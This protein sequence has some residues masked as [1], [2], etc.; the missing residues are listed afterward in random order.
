MPANAD[1][2]CFTRQRFISLAREMPANADAVCFT[3][4]RF[5]SFHEGNAG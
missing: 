3:R 1:A 5:I 4:Q 2:V